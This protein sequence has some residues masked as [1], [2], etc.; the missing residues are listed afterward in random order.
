MDR[1][2]KGSTP[3]T[4]AI[5]LFLAFREALRMLKE[6][7][8]AERLGRT[9]RLGEACRA[10]G[11]A[12]GLR[13]FPEEPHASNTV[14]AFRYPNGVEDAT[15]RPRLRDKHGVIVAG[16]QGAL[17]G[18]IFRIGHM[19]LCSLSDLLTTFAAIEEVL[20]KRGHSLERAASLEAIGMYMG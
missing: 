1:L 18:K 3:Y 16:G 11:R 17:Q 19:G 7:G 9:A 10:A 5:H 6:E 4:P 13:L 14:S 8:L 12:I 15:F 2:E 20:T